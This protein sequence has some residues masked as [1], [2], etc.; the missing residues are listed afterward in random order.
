MT[1]A[2]PVD[3]AT[4]PCRKN[5]R[6]NN[7]SHSAIT[8]LWISTLIRGVRTGEMRGEVSARARSRTER[9]V[10]INILHKSIAAFDVIR[11]YRHRMS[12]WCCHTYV[13]RLA[14]LT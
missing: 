3:Q 8:P 2:I 11:G 4:T 6:A 7:T 10:S 12:V 5:A 13:G 14:V 1:Y 9:G